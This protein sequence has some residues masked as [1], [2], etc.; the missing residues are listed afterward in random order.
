LV[1]EQYK[2]KGRPEPIATSAAADARLGVRFKEDA[3]LEQDPR[4]SIADVEISTES[5]VTFAAPSSKK[6]SISEL[7]FD[8][9]QERNP[10]VLSLILLLFFVFVIIFPWTYSMSSRIGTLELQHANFR[11]SSSDM[12][13]HLTFLHSFVVILSSNISGVRGEL[14]DHW[15]KFQINSELVKNVDRW[16]SQ[17]D[18]IQDQITRSKNL[19]L[20]VERNP[21]QSFLNRPSSELHIDES[22]SSSFWLWTILILI[23]SAAIYQFRTQL[24][25]LLPKQFQDYL[26][27]SDIDIEL[28]HKKND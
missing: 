8:G 2:Q 4:A 12:E 22:S 9:I 19:L 10:V 15:K 23:G 27:K 18:I 6:L 16:K 17:L 21:V 13:M 5:P 24:I 25:L 7:I 1:K 28:I 26:P 20:F 14:D 3:A 11:R